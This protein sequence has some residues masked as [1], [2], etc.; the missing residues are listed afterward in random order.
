[1]QIVDDPLTA[2]ER[3]TA[4]RL[5]AAISDAAGTEAPDRLDLRDDDIVQ[6][7]VAAGAD[8]DD[9]ARLAEFQRRGSRTEVWLAPAPAG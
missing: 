2:D 8:P 3:A 1:M 4:W 7:V 6:E 9:V 5:E